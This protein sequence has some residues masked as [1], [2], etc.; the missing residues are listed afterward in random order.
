M[1]R[2]GGWRRVR[3]HRRWRSPV[4]R[5]G[6]EMGRSGRW[7]GGA[8]RG[9]DRDR[10]SG[11]IERSSDMALT[12]RWRQ[13]RYRKSRL[14]R[15]REMKIFFIFFNLALIKCSNHK[16]AAAAACQALSSKLWT[17]AAANSPLLFNTIDAIMK[18]ETNRAAWKLNHLQWPA[19]NRAT[20]K[21]NHLQRTLQFSAALNLLCSTNSIVDGLASDVLSCQANSEVTVRKYH[22]IPAYIPLRCFQCALPIRDL[23]ITFVL[24][25]FVH[26]LLQK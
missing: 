9:R 26:G 10:E 22:S 1:G 23:L 8:A 7:G 3:R 20:R 15:D 18:C 19:Q 16:E 25:S 14:E 11:E 6:E 13:E 2:G 5:T 12:E 17:A 21:L 24:I 4:H